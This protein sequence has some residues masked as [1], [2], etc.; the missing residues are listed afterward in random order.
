MTCLQQRIMLLAKHSAHLPF[1]FA[2]FNLV[3]T[4]NVSE[5]S[6]SAEW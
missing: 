5:V 6:V 2:V 4:N 3:G 1:K